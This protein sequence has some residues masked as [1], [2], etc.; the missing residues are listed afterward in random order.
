MQGTAG[1]ETCGS[2]VEQE[3]ADVTRGVALANLPFFDSRGEL[4]TDK[5][6]LQSDM[7]IWNPFL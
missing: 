1:R 6:A 2:Q 4:R 5:Q 7:W 3:V